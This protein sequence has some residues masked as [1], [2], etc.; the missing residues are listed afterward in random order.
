MQLGVGFFAKFRDRVHFLP[1]S[2][3]WACLLGLDG[4]CEWFLPP[5]SSA[6]P[7]RVFGIAQQRSGSAAAGSGL[8]VLLSLLFASLSAS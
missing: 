5:G 1:P 2:L 8:Q 4:M 3:P 7:N 6:L